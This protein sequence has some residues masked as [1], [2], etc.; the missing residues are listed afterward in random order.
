[1][2]GTAVLVSL[3]A[4]SESMLPA[5]AGG[6]LVASG[7]LDALAADSRGA[8]AGGGA[9]LGVAAGALLRLGVAAL[10]C[11]A[12]GVVRLPP[13]LPRVFC[14]PASGALC[15]RVE[16]R[17]SLCKDIRSPPRMFCIA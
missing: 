13:E 3:T 2:D 1:M 16:R 17:S 4:V 9:R 14:A 11:T 6:L 7:A 8:A 10:M 12:I 5:L 15:G